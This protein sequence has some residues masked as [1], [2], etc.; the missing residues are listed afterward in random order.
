[1]AAW[2]MRYTLVARRW[3]IY[4]SRGG[5]TI[6]DCDWSSDVCSSDLAVGTRG[7]RVP[8]RPGA[9]GCHPGS[10][11]PVGQP[12]AQGLPGTRAPH[13]PIERDGIPVSTVDLFGRGFVVLAGAAG[14]AWLPAAEAAAGTLGAPLAAYR[15]GPGDLVDL[16]DT[17]P[18]AY[19]VDPAGPGPVRPHR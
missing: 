1:M 19:G 14:G 4:S 5:H 9:S 3:K 16:K 12:D 13:V 6:F 17:W 11:E 18:T 2:R 8:G 15:V 10:G 7:A